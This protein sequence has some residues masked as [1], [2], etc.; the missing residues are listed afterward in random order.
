[1]GKRL[2]NGVKWG[3]KWDV[4]IGSKLMLNMIKLFYSD[5]KEKIHE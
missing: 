5:S 1:M 2:N 3:V 4:K